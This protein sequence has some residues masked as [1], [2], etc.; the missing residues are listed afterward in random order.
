M[1]SLWPVVRVFFPASLLLFASCLQS[2]PPPRNDALEKAE[3]AVRQA[4]QEKF[5]LE[6][7]YIL[8]RERAAKAQHEAS[9]Q[10]VQFMAN[11]NYEAQQLNRR[12]PQQNRHTYLVDLNT[13]LVAANSP[14]AVKPEF[15]TEA[16]QRMPKVEQAATQED[17]A[18]YYKGKWEEAVA[19][20]QKEEQTRKEKEKVIVKYEDEL[21]AKEKEV[22][23]KYDEGMQTARDQ[24]AAATKRVN[25]ATAKLY[26]QL[27]WIF[28][29]GALGSGGL[30]GFFF[31]SANPR[32]GI[33]AICGTVI[34]GA[35]AFLTVWLQDNQWVVWLVLLLGAGAVTAAFIARQ[36]WN[37]RDRQLLSL[38]GKRDALARFL[39]TSACQPTELGLKA[40]EN[41]SDLDVHELE[42]LQERVVDYLQCRRLPV[43]HF[44][45]E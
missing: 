16:E 40:N 1:N 37:V 34:F 22:V 6:K 26:R 36:G 41:L 29:L 32:M 5:E 13:A 21:R 11:A 33:Y 12:N 9:L 2:L 38:S 43:P 35:G 19:A 8:E 23:V 44:L 18:A 7:Q 14:V 30:A 4:Q 10:R 27:V 31:Y 3:A 17:A 20:Q 45:K 39:A 15:I 42:H 24:L 25:E 28:G